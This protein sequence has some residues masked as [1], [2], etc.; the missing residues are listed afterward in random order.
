MTDPK[1]ETFEKWRQEQFETSCDNCYEGDRETARIVYDSARA[2]LEAKIKR[3]EEENA[4]RLSDLIHVAMI[5]GT[6]TDGKTMGD[7]AASFISQVVR[8][9]SELEKA[10]GLARM[11]QY[12]LGE[13]GLKWITAKTA[14]ARTSDLVT[15]FLQSQKGE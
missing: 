7:Q 3:L 5:L 6:S 10:V 4:R 15:A 8:L 11:V 12:M 13:E 9:R 14:R 2:D 1:E